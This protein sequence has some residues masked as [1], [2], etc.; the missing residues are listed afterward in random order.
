MI[1]REMIG[2]DADPVRRLLVTA[3]GGE[4]EADLVAALA[5]D[6]DLVFAA[7]A[8][9]DAAL[10]GYIAFSRLVVETGDGPFAAVA[11]APLAV[12]PERQ[13]QGIGAA[14]TGF[15]HEQLRARGE[16]LSVVLGEPDYYRRLGYST[17]R[18]AAFDSPYPAE[19]LMALAFAAA[20]HRGRLVYP[21][22]FAGL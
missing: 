2:Q 11:L 22:A 12:A 3:F 20:P 9:D 16:A 18:A 8:Q 15:A 10:V 1:L 21:R 5:R 17:E 19:Y 4:D 13:R 6:G 7:V 14:L